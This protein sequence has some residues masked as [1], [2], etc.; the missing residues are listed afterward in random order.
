MKI[1]A[2]AGNLGHVGRNIGRVGEKTI[3]RTC[4]KVVSLPI[5]PIMINLVESASSL[6]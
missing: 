4:T 2:L 1:V 5:Q 6:E 3:G